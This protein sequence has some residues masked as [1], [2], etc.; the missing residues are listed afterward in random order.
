MPKLRFKNNIGVDFEMP[1]EL[2]IADIFNKIKSRISFGS[3]YF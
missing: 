2:T 3:I 1:D